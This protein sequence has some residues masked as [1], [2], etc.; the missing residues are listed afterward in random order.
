MRII[1]RSSRSVMA[2]NT[3]TA[4]GFWKKTMG[5]MFRPGMPDDH[6]FLMEFERE[7]FH[8]VWMLFM[9]FPIDIVFLDAGKRVT[10][11]FENVE[12]MGLNP[13]TW[14]TYGTSGRSRWILEL[15]AGTV[16]RTR[17]HVNDVLDF[18]RPE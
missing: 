16:R 10:G 18:E 14:K 1:N 7:G 9:R 6:C 13:R 12:P 11:V 15:K 2:G 4:K 5:L 8:S 3:E 17:T